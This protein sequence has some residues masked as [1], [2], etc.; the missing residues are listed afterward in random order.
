MDPHFFADADGFDAVYPT[1]ALLQGMVLFKDCLGQWTPVKQ[2]N[3]D[4]G[5]R[6]I[7]QGSILGVNID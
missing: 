4:R 5:N 7:Q 2:A 1:R 3:L 6:E